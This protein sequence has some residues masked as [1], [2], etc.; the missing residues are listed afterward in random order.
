MHCA[1]ADA[2]RVHERA[3]WLL[4]ALVDY[5]EGIAPDAP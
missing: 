3:Q 4:E 2:E 1:E 5:A